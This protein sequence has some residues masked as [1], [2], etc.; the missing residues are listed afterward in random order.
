MDS[1]VFLCIDSVKVV[2]SYQEEGFSC[3]TLTT[4]KKLQGINCSLCQK[5]LVSDPVTLFDNFRQKLCCLD[6]PTHLKSANVH[7]FHR[8]CLTDFLLMAES[9]IKCPCKGCFT[10][11]TTVKTNTPIILGVDIGGVIIQKA[12]GGDDDPV[13][14]FGDNWLSTPSEP[15]VLETLHHLISS[16]IISSNNVYLVSKCG[17][18]FQQKT[19]QYLN[20]ID[21][22]PK[23]G[24][25]PENVR[26]CEERADK[27]KICESLLINHFV[28]DSLSVLRNLLAI[29]NM[30]TRFFYSP[31]GIP[32]GSHYM[33]Y[34]PLVTTVTSWAEIQQILTPPKPNK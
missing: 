3:A 34:S 23:T 4:P 16:G 18:Q 24:I 25:K 26:F 7:V 10:A 12:Q 33:C 6:N 30:K 2:P 17:S 14:F 8:W 22:F 31:E 32:P 1:P 29:P 9:D 20:H 5:S 11:P 13:S 27:A 15:G 28:D 21:F 19:L